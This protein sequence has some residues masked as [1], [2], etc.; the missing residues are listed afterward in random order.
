MK[1]KT[2]LFNKGVSLNLLKRYWP[3]WAGYFVLLLLATPVVLS[4]RVDRLAPGEMLNYTLLNTGV[5]V[6]YISMAVGV[7]SAMAMFNYLY[8]TKSCGM[9]NM[10]PI[11]RETMFITAFLTSKVAV[12]YAVAAVGFLVGIVG[13]IGYDRRLKKQ[14]GLTF[15]I[16]RLF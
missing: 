1:S 12:Q 2:S 6:V 15:H 16:V 3:L 7:L 13:A 14:G 4:G 10:L 5:D 11:R 9:M 8:S